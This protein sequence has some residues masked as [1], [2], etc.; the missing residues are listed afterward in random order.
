MNICPRCGDQFESD[1]AFCP[2]DGSR[3][4][5]A[6]GEA[7]LVGTIIAERYRITSR[8]G[9]GGMGQVFKAEHIR[10]KRQCAIK[11]LRASLAGDPEATQRFQREAENASQLSHPNVAQIYDFGEHDGLVY[12]A[13][14]FIAGESLA[15]MLQRQ[16]AIH[17]DVAADIIAQSAAALEAAH[18]RSVLHRDVKPDNIMLA[19][20]TDGTYQVKLVDF[21]IARAMTSEEQRVTRTGLVIGT[22]EFMSPEQIAGEELDARSDLYALA[23][24]AF[25]CLTG[26]DAFPATSS[27]QNLI[28]RLTSRPRTLAEVR[29]D[30]TWPLALQTVFD[31]A[32][33][34]DPAERYES[35][36]LFAEELSTAISSMTPSE[37]SALYRK[38][39]DQRVVSVASRTPHGDLGGAIS[40]P[41]A[42]PAA[43]VPGRVNTGRVTDPAMA[44]PTIEMTPSAAHT[45]AH[46]APDPAMPPPYSPY[47]TAHHTGPPGYPMGYP[48]TAGY[49]PPGYPMP[50]GYT[51]PGQA[52]GP[53]GGYPAPVGPYSGTAGFPAPTL[54]T[55]ADPM[56]M[57]RRRRPRLMPWV[58]IIGVGGWAY[59]VATGKTAEAKAVFDSVVE[60]VSGFVR[61]SKDRIKGESEPAAVPPA[62]GPAAPATPRERP[63]TTTPAGKTNPTPP[64]AVT[65][66]SSATANV[67]VLDMP[68]PVVKPPTGDSAARAAITPG[69]PF[70]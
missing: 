28:M 40:N 14:E 58:F 55:P 22:P 10:M 35:I 16:A 37:T 48:P 15:A 52:L 59:I 60:N 47:P 33:A 38:A 45:A 32:L 9:G 18:V 63:G 56:P 36:G 46:T 3:L 25:Q 17:P 27:K 50:P 23:L 49:P 42:V 61:A 53:Y 5:A 11:V 43:V 12:L 26:K 4:S 21:G 6:R 30:M 68:P 7:D 19:K 1:V 62:K 8:L 64:P 67:P 51:T 54:P 24:V 70:D 69:T 34:P 39:L 41:S 65:T 20:N 57:L 29:D 2:K 44:Q 31:R 13:M 66:D